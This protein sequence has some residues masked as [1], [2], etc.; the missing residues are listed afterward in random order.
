MIYLKIGD[1]TCRETSISEGSGSTL[2][3]PLVISSLKQFKA[4]CYISMVHSLPTGM[5]MVLSNWV[6]TPI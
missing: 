4:S 2:F 1:M 6:I 3:V 5:S